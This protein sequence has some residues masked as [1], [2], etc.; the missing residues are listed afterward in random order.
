MTRKRFASLV[1]LPRFGRSFYHVAV[2]Y[3]FLY[4]VAGIVFAVFAANAVLVTN[5]IGLKRQTQEMSGVETVEAQILRLSETADRIEREL[6]EI[7]RANQRIEEKTGI[8][9]RTPRG[10]DSWSLPSRGYYTV[11]D[12]RERLAALGDEIAER[13]AITA[14]A[15]KEIDRLVG[16]LSQ[17]PSIPPVKRVKIN[18]GFGYRVHP[19]YGRWEFHEGIDIEGTYNTPIYATADGAVKFSDWRY[20]YG[21]MVSI[22]HG[23]GFSTVYAHNSRN[24]VRAGERVRKGQIVAFVGRTGTTTGTHV[25][26]EVRYKNRIVNPVKFLNLTIK[27]VSRY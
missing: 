4:A 6:S 9:I 5:Y 10:E 15:E 25:H 2:S 20:G 23:N 11:D 8:T 24:L 3:R 22:D 16:V 14:D 17:I 12:V 7:E 27:D 18:S 19:L 21:L 26:Y 1:I 13:K